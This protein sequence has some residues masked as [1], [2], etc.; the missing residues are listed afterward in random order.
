MD[1]EWI[2]IGITLG[3]GGV[4]VDLPQN[5]LK[6]TNT[7]IVKIIKIYT[8]CFTN[9]RKSWK[10]LIISLRHQARRF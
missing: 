7:S 4:V 8:F 3:C 6:N 9:L 10:S 5:P 1:H 2:D